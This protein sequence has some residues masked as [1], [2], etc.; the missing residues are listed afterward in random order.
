MTYKQSISDTCNHGIQTYE[1][2]SCLKLQR[3]FEELRSAERILAQ[4][5]QA[6]KDTEQV[7]RMHSGTYPDLI[8]LTFA[9]SDMKDTVDRLLVNLIECRKGA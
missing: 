7:V 6:T 9:V 2:D 3:A 8:A 1:G 5:G 4:L